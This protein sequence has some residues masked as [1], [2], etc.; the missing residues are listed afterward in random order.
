MNATES[1][2]QFAALYPALYRL[3]HSRWHKSEPRPSAEALAVM[4]HLHLS[5]PLTITEA[6]AHFDR[7]QSAMS[8]L[9]DRAHAAGWVAR[10]PDGRDRRRTLVW[11]TD[12]GL[13]I[14]ERSRRVLDA[15]Q[16]ERCLEQ[17][18]P[19]ERANLIEG[20]R[21]LVRAAESLTPDPRSET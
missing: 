19:Q 18:T 20:M 9:V 5:G 2:R 3:L 1:A 13:D 4:T 10:V 11:L 8:E 16:L 12:A 15:Q 6:A 17:L 21:A 7:A 14:L